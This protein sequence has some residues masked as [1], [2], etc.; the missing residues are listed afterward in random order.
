MYTINLLFFL[1]D[2]TQA[3]ASGNFF[4]FSF[5]PSL[6][7]THTIVVVVVSVRTGQDILVKGFLSFL[8]FSFLFS[9]GDFRTGK[10][11]GSTDSPS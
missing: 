5:F 8:L 1:F 11:R 7:N 10:S 9:P 3:A 2:A 6:S 4:S